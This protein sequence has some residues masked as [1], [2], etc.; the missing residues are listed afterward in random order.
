[1]FRKL[2]LAA[3]AALSLGATAIGSSTSAQA[4]GY[5]WPGYGPHHECR[6]VRGW[7]PGPFGGHYVYRRV[8]F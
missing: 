3:L 4:Y 5:G 2:S 8:C 6:I 7:E 1:M